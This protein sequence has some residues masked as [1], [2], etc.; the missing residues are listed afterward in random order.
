MTT[1]AD[2]KSLRRTIDL[3]ARA[4][5]LGDAPYSSLLVGPDGAMLAEAHITVRRDND[6]SATR[7]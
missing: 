3:A 7:N 5:P 1:T 6:I 2:E 4:V